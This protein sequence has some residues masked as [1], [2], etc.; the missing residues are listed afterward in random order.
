MNVW[1][2]FEISRYLTEGNFPTMKEANFKN[3]L[4]RELV[5]YGR[6]LTEVLGTDS[7]CSNNSFVLAYIN[8]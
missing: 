4:I 3:K 6:T 7:L 8:E 1:K 2:M 5:R